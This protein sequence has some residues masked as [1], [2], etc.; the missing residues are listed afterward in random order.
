MEE[1]L[2]R[3][4]DELE[5]RVTERTEEI[6]HLA[7]AVNNALDGVILAHGYTIFYANPAFTRITGYSEQEL[8]NKNASLF[9]SDEVPASFYEDIRKRIVADKAWTGIYPSKRKDGTPIYLQLQASVIEATSVTVFICHDVTEKLQLE[10]KLRQAHKMEAIGTLAGGIAHDFNN[11]L[12]AII[13]FTEMAIEDVPD[14]PLVGKNLQN[15]MTSAIRARD[16]VKQILA[17][18]RKASYERIPVALSP[19]VQETIKLLRASI[20]A[21][22]DLTLS[23]TAS[24]DTVIAAPVEVQQIVMNLAT[25]ALLALQDRQGS[26]E[27]AVSNIDFEPDGTTWGRVSREYIQITIKD[28]GVG[29]APG[30]MKRI[31]DPFFTTREVGKGSGM[32]LAVVY[33]IVKDLGGAITVESEPGRGSTFRVFLPGAGDAVKDEGKQASLVRGNEHILFVD[34]EALIADWGREALTRLGYTVTTVKDGRQALEIFSANP[35]LFD[36][37]ITDQAMPQMSGS[38]LCVELLRT[39]NDIPI[40]LCTGHSETTSAEKAEQFGVREFL[41]KPLTRHELAS[42]VRRVLDAV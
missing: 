6:K 42:A 12:A 32:G 8:M 21:T 20:P 18:S 23:M 38:D 4:R 16:L 13:G 37:I 5:R 24:R 17:F 15:V 35:S 41:M 7:E 30:V 26:L 27:I 10:E 40:I 9:R 29:M 19:I 2:R 11:I 36:L 34:D 28:S 25:N 14:R 1:G 31:F 39:R 3:S 33:G 22:V